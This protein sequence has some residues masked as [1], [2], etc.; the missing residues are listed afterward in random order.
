MAFLCQL[1]N[2]QEINE[3]IL[4]IKV[5]QSCKGSLIK[6]DN[7]TAYQFQSVTTFTTSEENNEL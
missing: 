7:G 1:N 5:I 4:K 2:F 6:I 3:D